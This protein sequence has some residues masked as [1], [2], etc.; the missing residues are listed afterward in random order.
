MRES[1]ETTPIVINGVM[2]VTIAFDHVFALDARTGRQLWSYAHEMGPIT[3]FCCGPNNRGVAV[4][5]DMVYLATLDARPVALD[6]RTGELVWNFDTIPESSIGVWATRDATGRDMHRDIAAEKAAL[7]RPATATRCLA[8]AS[9]AGGNTQ[10]D[11]KRGNSIIA[12][13]LAH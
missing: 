5:G 13:K 7:A 10:L 3:T 12:F 4:Y 1:L 2:H 6:A 8:A 9:G 11:Y